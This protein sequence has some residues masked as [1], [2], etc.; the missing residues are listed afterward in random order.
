MSI[1][2]DD[3]DYAAAK[4][5][6]NFFRDAVDYCLKGSL[7]ELT[8]L[9]QDYLITNS[10]V[11]S[12]DLLLD[13]KSEGKTLLHVAASGG[14]AAIVDYLISLLKSAKGKNTLL[15]AS[16]DRGFTPLINATIS[17]SDTIIATFLKNGADVNALNKDGAGAV[18]FAA[19]DGSV[20]R[21]KLLTDAG[22][23]IKA[24][25]ET[26]EIYCK[27]LCNGHNYNSKDLRS[28]SNSK[29]SQ[30]GLI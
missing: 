24:M 19:G 9:I 20:S 18:H 5:A 23:N 30:V 6:Q 26:G 13:F 25:S 15:N 12:Q 2:T 3:R 7:A 14:H 22:A 8:K 17:E 4:T 29:S 1:S 28:N 10:K 21:L 27:N 16:D 11:N